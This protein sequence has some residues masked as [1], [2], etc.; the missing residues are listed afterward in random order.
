MKLGKVIHRNLKCENQSCAQGK[1]LVWPF[2]FIL[3]NHLLSLPIFSSKRSIV[4]LLSVGNIYNSPKITHAVWLTISIFNK[5]NVFKAMSSQF[6]YLSFYYWMR[7]CSFLLLA[8][9]ESL[10]FACNAVLD[11]GVWRRKCKNHPLGL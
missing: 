10:L 3:L 6:W 5:F 9:C 4:V 2:F 11:I 7:T 8:I 1:P